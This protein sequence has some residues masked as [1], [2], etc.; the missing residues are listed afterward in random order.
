VRSDHAAWL[1]IK[2]KMFTAR[3]PPPQGQALRVVHVQV[4]DNFG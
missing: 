4:M 3:L 2:A 1:L